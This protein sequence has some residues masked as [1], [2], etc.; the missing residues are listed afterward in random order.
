MVPNSDEHQGQTRRE[1]GKASRKQHIIRT[2]R[3]MLEETGEDGFS[4]RVL[5]K[6]AGCSPTTPYNLFGTKTGV[7]LEV[8]NADLE[9]FL[10]K[11][12]SVESENRVSRVFDFIDMV[13]AL[14]SR[15]PGFYRT[16]MQLISAPTPTE[17]RKGLIEPR[18]EIYHKLVSG[19][20]AQ[21]ALKKSVN[22]HLLARTM[23]HI[24]TSGIL[25]WSSGDISIDELR[26]ELFGGFALIL[27]TCCL[28]SYSSYLSERFAATISPH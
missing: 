25:G 15:E 6:R 10:K 2:A 19:M 11:F 14:Y 8:Y 27:H 13:C 17:L 23:A 28:S 16:M 4:M 26:H 22:L 3:Q 20:A 7:L 18:T 1:Q 5:A 12:D 24:M 9:M 21:G